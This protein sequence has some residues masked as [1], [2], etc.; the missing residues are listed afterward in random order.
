MTKT[1]PTEQNN[2]PQE[3][4]PNFSQAQQEMRNV[5]TQAYEKAPEYMGDF[6]ETLRAFAN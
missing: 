6:R 4:T 2:Q 5:V 1:V 3:E